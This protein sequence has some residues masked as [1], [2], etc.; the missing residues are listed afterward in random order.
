MQGHTIIQSDRSEERQQGEAAPPERTGRQLQCRLLL[1]RFLK[2]AMRTVFIL[3]SLVLVLG[4][5]DSRHQPIKMLAFALYSNQ[6]LLKQMLRKSN[7]LHLELKK[8]C[9]LGSSYMA[10]VLEDSSKAALPAVS[11]GL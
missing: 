3:M 6:H 9:S 5:P 1:Q 11:A 2:T 7:R 10:E 4:L 8:N